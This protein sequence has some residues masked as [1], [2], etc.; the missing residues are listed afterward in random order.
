MF[1]LRVIE[2]VRT[3]TEA[4]RAL[5]EVEQGRHP[6]PDRDLYEG[7]SIRAR[8]LDAATSKC[9]PNS[10][11]ARVLCMQASA[12]MNDAPSHERRWRLDADTTFQPESRGS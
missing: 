7:D 8:I 9:D 4:H 2:Q 3:R 6:H 1:V 12:L 5:C 11:S 10:A